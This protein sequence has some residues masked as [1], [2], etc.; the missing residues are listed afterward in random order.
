MYEHHLVHV[1]V[2]SAR[3]IIQKHASRASSYLPLLPSHKKNSDKMI[4][5]MDGEMVPTVI[6]KEGK[7]K[8]KN[9]EVAWQEMRIGVC[10]NVGEVDWGY[11]SSFETPEHLG[12][13]LKDI[14]YCFGFNEKTK[15]QG[16]G[17]GAL[18]IKEQGENIVGA[19]F[20]YL[21][22]LFH[23]SEYFCA[24]FEGLRLAPKKEM[25]CLKEMAEKGQMENVIKKLKE[26]QEFAPSHEGLIA[27]IRY[28]ENRPGQFDYLEAK[29]QGFPLGSGKVE[30]SHRSLIQKRLKI[31]GAW[32][33]K[34]NAAAMGDLRTIRANNGWE[35]LWNRK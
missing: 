22:D 30:S 31:P 4:I 15:V 25:H 34:E 21:I 7:D 10:Q 13:R 8:R 17:D 9:R 16:I 12:I 18:W 26:E 6:C 24:A 11:A 5:E 27:C 14:M 3:Q 2:S 32:W 19:N 20:K 1:P 35:L 23:L 29:A 28:I 33:L